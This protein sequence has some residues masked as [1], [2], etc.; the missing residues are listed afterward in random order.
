QASLE[1][2]RREAEA[3][4]IAKSQFLAN[5]SHEIRTPMNG[6][7]GMAELLSRTDLDERQQRFLRSMRAASDAMVKINNDIL[8][9][10]K[11]ESGN[12][13]FVPEPCV[14]RDLVEDVGQLYAARAQTKGLELVCYIEPGVPEVVSADVLRL[15]QVLGNLV[16]NA[17]K[18]TDRG[19]IVVRVSDGEARDGRRLVYFEVSDTGPGIPQDQQALIFE[20]YKQLANASSQAGTGLGLP[21]A[22][23]LVKLMGGSGIDLHSTPGH[24]SR[25]VFW[26]PC[27]VL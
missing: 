15:R 14:L 23:R 3:A 8:D 19:E 21:I 10:T 12:M 7:V 24:G 26:L 6:V 2:S 18:Y 5:M 4:N 17:V 13:E 11:I 25:F 22:L 9:V 20:P 16:S 27:A 1:A